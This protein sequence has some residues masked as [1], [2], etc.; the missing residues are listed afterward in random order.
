MADS[1]RPDESALDGIA[2]Q[3]FGF[4]AS[5]GCTTEFCDRPPGYRVLD[6]S[7]RTDR[8]GLLHI[9]YGCFPKE[10]PDAECMREVVTDLAHTPSGRFEGRPVMKGLSLLGLG[11]IRSVEELEIR[12]AVMGA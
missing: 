11:G 6:V 2:K 3:L 12:L 7:C 1:T 5:R 9:Y 4:F 10:C 8:Y